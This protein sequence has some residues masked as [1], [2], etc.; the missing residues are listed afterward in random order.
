M[1]YLWEVLLEAK[2]EQIPEE[3]LRFV[4][5][6]QGSGYMELSLPCL[7]QTWLGEEEQ[8]EDINIEVNTYYRFYDIFCEMFPPDEAEFPSLRESLTNL[9]LHMLA[10]NDIG[11]VN[12]YRLVSDSH[13]KYYNRRPKI[14]KSEFM[15]Y[16][17]GILLGSA[18]EAGELFQA[19]DD[20]ELTQKVKALWQDRER[21]EKYV[22]NCKTVHFDTLEE[23]C[24]KLCG[25]YKG[26]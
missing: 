4:H 22:E 18:C 13:I 14:P 12:L 20:E 11:R 19:G 15:K 5:A 7:N 3:R 6:P 21:C 9:C 8:P 16:R 26:E 17:E 24:E 23:Y 10:Q 2:K 1:R 25:L